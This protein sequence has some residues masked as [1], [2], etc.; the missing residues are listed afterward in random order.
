[1]SG[2]G[3]VPQAGAGPSVVPV[4][5]HPAV[6]TD[7]EVPG[8]G[9]V[10]DSDVALVRRDNDVSLRVIRRNEG[11]RSIVELTEKL[12]DAVQGRDGVARLERHE[13]VA[14]D[15]LDDVTT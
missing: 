13:D 12:P 6:S 7:N 8:R 14:L 15:V 10:M 9:V 1:M 3:E 2:V 4:G 5:E 11:R